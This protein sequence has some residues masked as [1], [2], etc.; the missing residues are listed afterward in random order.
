[1]GQDYLFSYPFNFIRHDHPSI[2]IAVY[3]VS[4]T[5]IVQKIGDSGTMGL[6]AVNINIGKCRI[7]PTRL[8]ACVFT[9]INN[10][11]LM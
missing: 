10:N 8:P 2:I 11:N 4:L 9:I 5:F 7:W 3:K 1:M 6:A